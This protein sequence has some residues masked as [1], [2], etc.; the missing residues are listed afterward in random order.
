VNP[1]YAHNI[2]FDLELAYFMTTRRFV[3]SPLQ[4]LQFCSKSGDFWIN[5]R[6]G[7]IAIVNSDAV[8]KVTMPL[9]TSAVPSL[10]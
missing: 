5:D 6:I 7:N 10:E 8:Q 3:S 4:L 9:S 1:L 2:H